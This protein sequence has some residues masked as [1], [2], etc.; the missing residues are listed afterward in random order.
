M[1]VE[2]KDTIGKKSVTSILNV[3]EKFSENFNPEVYRKDWNKRFFSTFS[4]YLIYRFG[5][6]EFSYKIGE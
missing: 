6:T 2:I 4:G 3:P 5:L 1:K